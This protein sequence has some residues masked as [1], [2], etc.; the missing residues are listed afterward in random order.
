MDDM[1]ERLRTAVTRLDEAELQLDQARDVLMETMRECWDSGV[2]VPALVAETGYSRAY[3][4]E[5]VQ[6]QP[7]GA[8]RVT[9]RRQRRNRAKEG[10]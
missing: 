10:T 6:S 9:Q 2:Q 4:Y 5:L 3:V 8:S 1:T 7:Q